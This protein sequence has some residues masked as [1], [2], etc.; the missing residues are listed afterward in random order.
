MKL[1]EKLGSAMEAAMDLAEEAPYNFDQ[2]FPPPAE[3]TME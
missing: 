3:E 2:H 1:G